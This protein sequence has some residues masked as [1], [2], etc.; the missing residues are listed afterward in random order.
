[1]SAPIPGLF[2]AS[3]EDVKKAL[4]IKLTAR[5][6]GQ[7]KQ[8]LASATLACETQLH[9]RFYPWSGTRYFPWPNRQYAPAWRL[10]LGQDEV[11]SVSSLVAAGTTIS[12]SDYF[13]EPVN[14]GPPYTHIEI[15][16][17]SS[18][19]FG[20]DDT[21]QRAIAVTGV[22]GHSAVE[23]S[24][25]TITANI[26]TTTATTCAIS[27]SSLVGIGNIIKLGSERL[28]V[29]GKGM[30]DTGQNCTTLTA[31]N[32]DVAIT[33]VTAGTIA[34]DET[35][36]V[37]SERMLVVDVA[38]TT[39]TVKRA[40]DG[41]VLASHTN[42]ADMYAPRTLT[43]LR[44][45]LGTT[46]STHSSA[47]TVTRHVVPG[48]VQELCVAEA[49]NTLLQKQSGYGRVIGSGDNEREASGRGLRQIREDAYTAF[50]RKPRKAA[51]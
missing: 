28:I 35:I 12:S 5:S 40:H 46:A 42:G 1:M 36:L 21:H 26:T 20:S 17:A 37:D 4:D 45:Q 32:N 33:G 6:D 25:G 7:V 29:T 23:E 49:L 14:S 9:R 47:A 13:L 18:A 30:V 41:T 43:V 38:G 31:A 3:V 19:A 44:G 51:V 24:A 8:A 11:I 2:Y 15:D 16:L 27:D 48:L 34:V 39:L 22:F 50:G 10:W